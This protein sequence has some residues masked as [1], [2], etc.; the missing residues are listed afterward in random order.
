MTKKL[1]SKR[2][3]LLMAVLIKPRYFPNMSSLELEYL[4]LNSRD[5]GVISCAAK[6]G[7]VTN[8]NGYVCITDKEI[9]ILKKDKQN[10]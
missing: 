6:A 10:G 5:S 1:S 3:A 2:L 8:E 7:L 4:G 9:D